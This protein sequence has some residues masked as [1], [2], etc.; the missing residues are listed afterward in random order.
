MTA[1]RGRAPGPDGAVHDAAGA[2]AAVAQ[3]ERHAWRPAADIGCVRTDH[4]A[5]LEPVEHQ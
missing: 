1:G 3:V 2:G 5:D 4:F